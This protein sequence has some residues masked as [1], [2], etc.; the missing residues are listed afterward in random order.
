VRDFDRIEKRVLPYLSDCFEPSLFDITS[1]MIGGGSTGLRS[2]RRYEIDGKEALK[3]LV[4][5]N[6][7]YQNTLVVNGMY[8]CQLDYIHV[9]WY[10]AFRQC[11]HISKQYRSITF[12]E[13]MISL[14]FV[15]NYTSGVLLSL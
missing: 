3:K 7:K 14:H 6:Q 5:R 2:T 12:K 8:Y 13:M 11:L 1:C 4:S 15:M 10:K 9:E